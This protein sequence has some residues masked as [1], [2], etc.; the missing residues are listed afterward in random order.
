[1]MASSSLDT[2]P[3]HTVGQPPLGQPDED[4]RV[5][6]LRRELTISEMEQQAARRE[7]ARLS[8]RLA[9]QEAAAR[10]AERELAKHLVRSR[11]LEQSVS[12]LSLALRQV[13]GDVD[14]ALRSRAWRL[15]HSVTLALS[16]LA[17]RPVRTEGALVA[18]LARID[19]AQHA[20]RA[21][22]PV[23]DGERPRSGPEASAATSGPTPS[24]RGRG[25]PQPAPQEVER[26]R[27]GAP[28]P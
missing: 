8:E 28:G 26:A 18:A 14:R 9:Q 21:D 11:R 10:A 5:A 20:T 6:R 15:G 7:V 19:R 13:R 2:E 27:T 16:R 25:P 23:S 4:A 1:E 12:V 3:G 22:S 24:G 17:R